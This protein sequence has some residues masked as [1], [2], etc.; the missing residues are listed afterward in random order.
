LAIEKGGPFASV[1]VF[2]G[3]I[4]LVAKA[5]KSVTDAIP[6]WVSYPFC[7]IGAAF[8]GFLQ[9]K[10]Y[11]EQG[12]RSLL[13]NIYGLLC[14]VAGLVVI[15][16]REDFGWWLTGVL[17][18]LILLVGKLLLVQEIE[19]ESKERWAYRMELNIEPHWD[20]LLAR[21]LPGLERGDVYIIFEIIRRIT[22][23]PAEMAESYGY[24]IY[25]HKDGMRQVWS[26]AQK[27]FV[28][29]EVLLL[30]M[31]PW[32]D[33][34]DVVRVLDEVA[35]RGDQ[36][37]ALLE[38]PGMRDSIIHAFCSHDD[39]DK[40]GDYLQFE[41]YFGSMSVKF[42]TLGPIRDIVTGKSLSSIP[43]YWEILPFLHEAQ[44]HGEAEMHGIKKFPESIR[45]KLDEEGITYV[46]ERRHHRIEYSSK[47]DFDGSRYEYGD[48]RWEEKRGVEF[49]SD[50]LRHHWFS[51]EVVP[52]IRTVC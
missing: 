13:A 29:S 39:F 6:D 1:V 30:R 50:K 8:F 18:L 47:W 24:V 5:T 46:D 17:I 7:A 4:I 28:E 2:A 11:K 22:G 33:R 25:K 35:A 32:E 41:S 51:R 34:A 40:E 10:T 21:V 12:R 16:Q 45:K 9:Y 44:E 3:F 27:T 26:D 49:Y 14:M 38:R 31:F 37:Q 36:E 43:L 42:A 23:E 20:R 48:R 15:D 19:S 52:R